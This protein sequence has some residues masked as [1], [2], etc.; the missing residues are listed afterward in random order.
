[1]TRHA[2]T[3]EQW[4][5]IADLFPPPKPVDRKPRDRRRIMD[6]ILW[7]LRTGAPWHDLPACFGPWA[8]AWDLFDTWSND[9]LLLTILQRLQGAAVIDDELWCVDGTVVR[10]HKCA[11]GGGKKGTKTSRKTTPLVVAAAG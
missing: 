6:A 7:V 9:G 10:A 4:E 2:L 5:L 3:D 1:M 8:T 11:S